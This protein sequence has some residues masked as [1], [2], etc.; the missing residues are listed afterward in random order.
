MGGGVKEAETKSQVQLGSIV[1]EFGLTKLSSGYLHNV[2]CMEKVIFS[3]IKNN[4]VPSSIN[5]RVYNLVAFIEQAYRIME[6]GTPA[7]FNFEKVRE[8]YKNNH[9]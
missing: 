6:T 8:F 7:A 5:G 3:G 2:R 1:E 4:E 9:N